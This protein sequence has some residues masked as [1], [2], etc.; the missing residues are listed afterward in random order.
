MVIDIEKQ[1]EAHVYMDYNNPCVEWNIARGVINTPD[2]FPEDERKQLLSIFMANILSNDTAVK[3]IREL[4]LEDIRTKYYSNEVSRLRGFFV[5]ADLESLVNFWECNNWG[6][7]FRDEYLTDVGVYSTKYSKL[8]SNWISEIIN[9]DGTLKENCEYSAHKYW[10]GEPH[11]MK[12]PIWENIIEGSITIW[13]L[14]TKLEAL[15]NIEA[16]W[17]NSINILDYAISCAMIGNFDGQVVPIITG[18]LE[19][20]EISIDYAIRMKHR[21]DPYFIAEINEHRKKYPNKHSGLQKNNIEDHLPDLQNYSKKLNLQSKVKFNN[22]VL[23]IYKNWFN[24][25]I[26]NI[27]LNSM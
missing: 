11:P 24:S 15:K 23:S 2:C 5:F 7:H 14:E 13:S 20:I 10:K 27:N 8:D 22:F 26:N 17:P 6:S 9:D 4:Y 25:Q 21:L 18:N 16:L 12:P 19:N 1:F 3:L